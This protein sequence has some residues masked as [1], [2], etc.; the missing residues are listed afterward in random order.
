M[1]TEGFSQALAVIEAGFGMTLDHKQ[2][3]V[4]FDRLKTLPDVA[5]FRAA[6]SITRDWPHD[7]RPWVSDLYQRAREFVQPA[8]PDPVPP[9]ASL[10][11]SLRALAAGP[12]RVPKPGEVVPIDEA[13]QL[14]A[15]RII[16][17]AFP[18]T[19]K[20]GTLTY[21]EVYGPEGVLAAMFGQGPHAEFY[22]LLRG[23]PPASEAEPPA[24]EPTDA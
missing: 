21:R 8:T 22:A 3:R 14:V 18:R 7:R 9:H 19:L 12:A 23:R 16:A 2:Q 13:V 1:T 4:W 5:V 15:E 10:R 17:Q 11:G 24:E 6:D 20:D